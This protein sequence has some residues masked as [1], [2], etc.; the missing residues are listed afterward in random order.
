MLDNP[1]VRLG[2]HILLAISDTGTGI[3]PEIRD[4]VFEPLFTTK[5]VGKGTGLGLSLMYGFVKQSGGHIKLYSEPGYGTT[6]KLYLQLPA[7][8]VNESPNRNVELVAG[9]TETILVVE[10]DSL[11]RDFVVAQLKNL[12][13]QTVAMADARSALAYV[14]SGQPFDLAL[15]GGMTGRQ[16]VDAIAEH[17][18]QMRVLYTSGY[19]DGALTRDGRLDNSAKLLVKPYRKP[20]LAQMIRH[21]LDGD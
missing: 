1:G 2:R 9:G 3:P 19:T 7:D 13:Y 12:G 4:K 20:Q 18:T 5:E 8:A 17:R 15:P 11:V 10:D 6:V 16:L 14:E 21:A